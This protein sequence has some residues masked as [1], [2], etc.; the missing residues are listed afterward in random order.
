MFRGIASTFEIFELVFKMA[1]FKIN[2]KTTTILNIA[3]F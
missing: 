2:A 1:L 3:Q